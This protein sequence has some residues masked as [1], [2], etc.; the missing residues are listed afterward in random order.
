MVVAEKVAFKER[1]GKKEDH[2]DEVVGKNILP[3]TWSR[4]WFG[5]FLE[6]NWNFFFLVK[7]LPQFIQSEDLLCNLQDLVQVTIQLGKPLL[8]ILGQCRT[9]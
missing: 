8:V 7:V 5:H 4:F 6:K 3:R 1:M 9:S 2:D